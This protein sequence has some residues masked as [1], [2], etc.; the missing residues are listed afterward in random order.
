MADQDG[1]SGQNPQTTSPIDLPKVLLDGEGLA[2][3]DGDCDSQDDQTWRAYFH[4][5]PWDCGQAPVS[6]LEIYIDFCITT[7]SVAPVRID[8][9]ENPS[10]KEC[11]ALPDLDISADSFQ[12]PLVTQSR[13]WVRMIKWVLAR[14]PNAPM[15]TKQRLKGL[16]M[17]GYTMPAFSLTGCPS[18][19]AGILPRQHL[20]RFFH[21][22]GK[23]HN[24]LGRKWM[25]PRHAPAAQYAQAGA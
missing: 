17:I 5:L 6:A 21:H 4:L 13:T 9:P 23:I 22:N 15:S 25:P 16:A 2:A 3:G 18:F 1:I 11:F 8:D 24:S 12:V 10:T 14:W 7:G 20:W 19:R